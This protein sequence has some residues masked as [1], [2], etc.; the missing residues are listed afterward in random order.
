MAHGPLSVRSYSD[1]PHPHDRYDRDQ[2]QRAANG[3]AAAVA[4]FGIPE[5]PETRIDP[6]RNVAW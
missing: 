5:G 4:R 6:G 1:R 3:A 2:A